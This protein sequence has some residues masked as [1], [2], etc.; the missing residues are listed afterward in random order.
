MQIPVQVVFH[1]LAHSDALQSLIHELAAK[2]CRGQAKATRC[3]VAVEQPHRHRSQ[4]RDFHIRVCLHVAGGELVVER[5][6]EDAQSAAREAFAAL[7]RQLDEATQRA[8]GEVKH[9]A[10]D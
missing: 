3:L 9:H 10:G 5:A 1:G 2:A 7:R 4:G 6:G 8:R